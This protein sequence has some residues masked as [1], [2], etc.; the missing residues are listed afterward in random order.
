[1]LIHGTELVIMFFTFNIYLFIPHT[2]VLLLVHKITITS[3]QYTS[4]LMI[5]DCIFAFFTIKFKINMI[6]TIILIKLVFLPSFL[7]LFTLT[8]LYYI[9]MQHTCGE[10]YTHTTRSVGKVKIW[11]SYAKQFA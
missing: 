11:P 3:I 10:I 7:S 9:S 8:I 1:M 2:Y 6:T 4:R 5:K